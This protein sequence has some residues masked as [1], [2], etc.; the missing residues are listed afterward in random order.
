ML[1]T[2][3]VVRPSAT[4]RRHALGRGVALAASALLLAGCTIGASDPAPTVTVVATITAAPAPEDPASHGAADNPYAR[5]LWLGTVPLTLDEATNLGTRA[6]TP[7]QLRDRQLEPPAFLPDPASDAWTATITEVPAHV[8]ARSTWAPNC[9]VKLQDLSYIT[10]PYW[11]FDRRVHQGEMII[12]RTV[13]EDVVAAFKKIFAAKFPIEEMRVISLFDRD[14]PATGDQ[15]I[16]SGFTCRTIVG[17]STLWSE[18][19]KGYAID[20]NPFH[21]PYIRGNALFPELA[22]AYLDRSN[23]RLGMIGEPGVVYGAF[24]D[25]GWGWG[26][27]WATHEDWM[28]FSSTGG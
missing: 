21:N 18:H 9:P 4:R 15:N 12:H 24:T 11:G 10:M 25:I 7:E 27:N 3:L 17:T 23:W 8:A 22:E 20:I 1:P 6:E 2:S 16:T 14:S 5:P 19:S 26:G 13:A 28:H